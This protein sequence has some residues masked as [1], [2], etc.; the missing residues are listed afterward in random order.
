[1]SAAILSWRRTAAADGTSTTT[2]WTMASPPTPTTLPVSSWNGV[3]AASTTSMTRL[4]FSSATLN[5]TH[6]PYR[7]IAM[8]SRIV[9]AKLIVNELAKAAPLSGPLVVAFGSAGTRSNAGGAKS[10]A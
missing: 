1:M 5:A 6:W 4:F 2:Y 10:D 8:N 7:M 9:R 3:A